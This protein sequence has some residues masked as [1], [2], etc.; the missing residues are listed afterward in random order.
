[1]LRW[2]RQKRHDWEKRSRLAQVEVS[3]RWLLLLTPAI[4]YL[5]GMPGFFADISPD[6]LPMSLGATVAVL[7]L[8]QGGLSVRGLRV[9]ME[10]YLGGAEAPRRLLAAVLAAFALETAVLVVMLVRGWAGTAAAPALALFA[11]VPS[12]SGLYA[13][14]VSRRR[15]VVVPLVVS[16]LV[17]AAFALAG[18]A[19]P[20]L[21]GTFLVLVFGSLCGAFSVRG[22][23]W[24]LAVMRELDEAKEAQ[25]R[26][27]VAE[28]RLRF[29]R[30]LHDVMGRNLSVIALKS[31]LAT[32]LARRGADSAI[33]QMLQVQRLARE[34]QTEVREVVRG[35]REAGLETELAGARGVL[36]AAGVDC[37]V[38]STAPEMDRSVQSALGWVVREGATNVLRHADA[39]RCL[40]SL[41]TGAPGT[42][43]LLMENDGAEPGAADRGS[44]LT[45]LAER[46]AV[47]DGTLVRAGADAEGVFRLHAEVPLHAEDPGEV[48]GDDASGPPHADDASGSA[49]GDGEASGA[50]AG[51]GTFEEGQVG[52]GG[53][54][55]VA[56]PDTDTSRGASPD[57]HRPAPGEGQRQVQEQ[58]QGQGQ[59]RGQGQVQ[60]DRPGG[61][62]RRALARGGVTSGGGPRG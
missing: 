23:A 60:V 52:G 48:S 50:A 27:A 51:S 2:G 1:M 44:G 43:A 31:E 17:L 34:S 42:V 24:Y 33:E 26:L 8:V 59:G 21:L 54:L 3:T 30:D 32:Q 41:T 58:A 39:A 29:S 15:A 56:G 49:R 35:Y 38:E 14:T 57:G 16:A 9:A 55:A 20:S 37:R 11:V 53:R 62:L 10:C 6:R 28:E 45:G 46:L 36:R 25:S 7:A 61:L 12:L 13:L 40:I 18:M 19:W 4:Y 22:T 47:L 5:G